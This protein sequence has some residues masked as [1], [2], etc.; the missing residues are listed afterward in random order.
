M[1]NLIKQVNTKVNGAKC[2][3][4]NK[5]SNF[6]KWSAIMQSVTKI[7][8]TIG[9]AFSRAYLT[10]FTGLVNHALGNNCLSEATNYCVYWLFLDA[11]LLH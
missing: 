3:L 9:I 6:V 7:H 1:F 4:E 2:C 5:K 10:L 11:E 8:E